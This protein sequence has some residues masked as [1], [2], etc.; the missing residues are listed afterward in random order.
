MLTA[1]HEAIRPEAR[2]ENQNNG[3]YLNLDLLSKSKFSNIY[4][5]SIPKSSFS[6]KTASIQKPNFCFECLYLER[7]M[8]I[9]LLNTAFKIEEGGFKS[10]VLKYNDY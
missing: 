5:H 4:E 7:D 9:W 3:L 6:T 1:L 10:A 8:F 2:N